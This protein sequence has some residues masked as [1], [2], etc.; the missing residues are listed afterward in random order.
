MDF[1]P[2]PSNDL[3]AAAPPDL[4]LSDLL[5]NDVPM[6]QLDLLDIATVGDLWMGQ[7]LNDPTPELTNQLSSPPSKVVSIG[8][9]SPNRSPGYQTI[10]DVK[11]QQV[12]PEQTMNSSTL[13]LPSMKK[14]KN[15]FNNS[16][17]QR[18][19]GG[20]Y[21]KLFKGLL[22]TYVDSAQMKSKDPDTISIESRSSGN[23]STERY[24]STPVDDEP[25][26]AYAQRI[27]DTD[28]V[29]N[30]SDMVD[31]VSDTYVASNAS[32]FKSSASA[33]AS[34][35]S[36]AS[37]SYSLGRT[38]RRG[39]RRY[40]NSIK[41][42][43]NIY[44]SIKE[45]NERYKAKRQDALKTKRPAFFCTF[46][47]NPYTTSGFYPVTWPFC[48]ETQPSNE[49]LS[50]HSYLECD[51]LKQHIQR[52]HHKGGNGKL[53]NIEDILKEWERQAPP[54]GLNGPALHCGFCGMRFREWE[55]RVAHV[56]WH[57]TRGLDLSSWWP[58][59]KSKPQWTG[60]IRTW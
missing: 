8:E 58:G 23:F 37:F 52:V 27:P 16:R 5:K 19:L 55:C 43:K 33:S 10:C 30:E 7:S 35:S 6:H 22:L 44:L 36:H 38:P 24:L 28:E 18:N 47:G 49:H 32:S 42:S 59:R 15:W 51:H 11:S 4:G 20:M 9:P 45:S 60:G 34:A 40:K 31:S 54:L 26:S 1:R 17:A 14:F 25:A 13:S 41:E 39:R 29:Q 2:T 53:K 50:N 3:T 56:A 46:C 57:F 21:S 48:L 12:S